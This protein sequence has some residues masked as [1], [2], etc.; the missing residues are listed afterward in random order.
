MNETGQRDYH[1]VDRRAFLRSVTGAA[2]GAIALSIIGCSSDDDDNS[3]MTPAGTSTSEATRASG[4]ITPV[5][6][7]GEF[8]V[9]Q[10][11][12]FA[13][14]LLDAENNLVRNAQVYARFFVVNPDGQSGKLRGEG[15][16]QFVE[17]NVKD[18]HAHDSSG[19]ADQSEEAVAFYVATTPF[20]FEGKWAVELSATPEGAS[21]AVTIQAPFTVLAESVSPGLGTVPPASQNDTTETNSNTTSLCTR[22]PIC[23]LHDKVIGDY[24]GKGRPLVV[25][26]STPAFCET[27]F[28]GPVLEVLLTQVDAYKDRV[29]FIH[30]EVWQD[31]QA[32]AYRPAVQEWRLPGEPYTFFLDGSGTVASRLEAVFTEEELVTALEQLISA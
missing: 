3:E 12:R 7:T 32:Q 18:A 29:D 14:G 8:V 16:M 15:A 30:I 24:L 13:V 1:L 31:F 19:E 26:F 21:E 5:L 27:R 23:D 2:F 6:L 9:N 22:D 11:N 17:L 25:Q 4:A 20:D 28:C 10:D